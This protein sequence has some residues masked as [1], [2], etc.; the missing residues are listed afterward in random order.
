M[1]D[2]DRT[3]QTL[4]QFAFED[5][6]DQF[7]F[8]ALAEVCRWLGAS[9]AAW[10]TRSTIQV[11]GEFTEYPAGNSTARDYLQ[12]LRF[13]GG[14]RELDLNPLPVSLGGGASKDVGQ[15]LSYSHRGG[16]L[17]SM[18]LL[19]YPPG[20]KRQ[21]TSD[22]RRAIGHMVEAG[23]LALRQFIQRD[24]W[25]YSLGRPSRGTAALVDAAG[26]IYA[27]SNRFREMMGQEFGQREL[28]ALPQP[29]PKDSLDESGDF[30]QGMLHFRSSR[31]G[32]LYLLHARKPLP[33]DGLSPR[34][35]QIAR[36]LG[37]GKTFKSVAR[38]LGIAV[39]TVANHASRIYKKL[40]VFRREELVEMVRSPG[41]VAS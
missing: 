6:W 37:S 41:G 27:A 19:R 38:Q 13:E 22:V 32:S 23:S 7:R 31:R 20:S 11:S 2:L 40:G 36:A 3:I 39:S 1:A 35:Q 8:K 16:G 30:S 18:I 14:E 9:G 5:E 17:N 10:L 29:L 26:T 28:L 21:S 25:L 12:K 34:E 4:Y 33:L 15:V 24:E